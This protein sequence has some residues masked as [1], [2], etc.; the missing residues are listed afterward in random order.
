LRSPRSRGSACGGTSHAIHPCRSS[1]SC[2]RSRRC[3]SWTSTFPRT[4]RSSARHASTTWFAEL[5][6]GVAPDRTNIVADLRALVGCCGTPRLA[7][8]CVDFGAGRLVQEEGSTWLL[9]VV[10]KA[11]RDAA[12][13]DLVAPQPCCAS[14]PISALNITELASHRCRSW[15]MDIADFTCMSKAETTFGLAPA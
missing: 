2:R 15:P 4:W 14:A 7:S 10:Q 6:V 1:R 8:F 11:T 9:D 12:L 5:R 13:L 3:M